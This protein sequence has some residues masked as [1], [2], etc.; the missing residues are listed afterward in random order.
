MITPEDRSLYINAVTPPPGYVFD[1][2]L[3][4]TYTL[5]PDTLLS[6]PTHIALG[7]GAAGGDVDPI[8]ILESLRRLAGRFSVYADHAGLKVPASKNVLFGLLEDM[9]IPVKARKGGVFHPKLW[10]LRF[11]RPEKDT[12][13]PSLM[14]LLVLSRN[15]T[16]DRSW[17]LCLQI[18]GQTCGRNVAANHPLSNFIRVLPT[19]AVRR[20]SPEKRRQA[21]FMAEEVRK[22]RWEFP[23]GFEELAFHCIGTDD[24]AWR[25]VGSKRMAV[26][27]PFISD[28]ALQFLSKYTN[29]LVAVISRPEELNT[30]ERETFDCCANWYVLEDAAETEDGEETEW[31]DTVG[32]HAKMYICEE[33]GRTHLYMGSANATATALCNGNNVELLVELIGPKHRVGGIN[34]FLAKDGLGPL[35]SPYEPP[36][37]GPVQKTKEQK[38]RK[39]LDTAKRLLAGSEL[40]L[41]CKKKGGAWELT[42]L[43]REPV[44]LPGIKQIKAWPVTV[45]ENLAA[46]AEKLCLAGSAGLGTYAVESITGLI[47]FELTEGTLRLKIQLALNLPVEGLPKYREEAIFK[48]IVKDRDDFMRYILLLIEETVEDVF[49]TRRFG[50]AT[51]KTAWRAG[52]NKA[53]PVL[54]E[55]VRAFSRHPDKLSR[56]RDIIKKLSGEKAGNGIVP[57][58]FLELWKVFDRAY[59]G[60]N[61]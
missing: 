6:L 34:T 55:L 25:P 40:R 30:L 58:E 39:V 8:I 16:Y 31:R 15:I 57:A 4:T 26:V 32:L 59:T 3:A 44:N 37:Q 51:D 14:R 36:E 1:Q 46:D 52:G 43:A 47:A 50:G 27:S 17:D 10:I 56:L 7:Q 18:E 28:G 20:T 9:I 41:R 29:A 13:E 49:D 2:A 12:E 61:K 19:F 48:M 5:D 33:N 22:T 11:V 54:E 35:L 42:L 23:E 60:K 53:V 45:S 24:R 21:R 38:A